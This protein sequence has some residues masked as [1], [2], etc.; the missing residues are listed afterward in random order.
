MRSRAAW[1]AGLPEDLD[2]AGVGPEDVHDHA[3]RGRLARPVRSEQAEDAAPGHLEGEVLHRHVAGEGL[4]YPLEDD[5]LVVHG[6]SWPPDGGPRTGS[7]RFYTP[8]VASSP[9]DEARGLSLVALSTLAYGVLPILGQARLR[10]GRP[11]PAPP[12]LAL[13]HRGGA[14]RAP[15]A[16]PPAAP[17]RARAALGDRLRV[18]LQLDRLLPRPRADPGVGDRARPLHLPGDRGAPRRPGRRRAVHLARPPR[19]ARR[20]RGL[21]AHRGGRPGGGAAAALRRRLGPRPRRSSTPRTSS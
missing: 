4:A 16:R 3:E 10:R 12:R 11:A 1:S 17:A 8:A 2:R 15:G 5:G 14:H 9:R 6:T 19:D 18:R 20:L 13:R 21:R 7:G